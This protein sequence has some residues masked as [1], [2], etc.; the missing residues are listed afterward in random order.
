MKI[1]VKIMSPKDREKF[2]HII[3]EVVRKDKYILMRIGLMGRKRA[4]S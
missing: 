4:H 2:R 3:G 1:R